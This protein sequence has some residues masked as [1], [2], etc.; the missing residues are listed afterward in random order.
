MMAMCRAT[1]RKVALFFISAMTGVLFAFMWKNYQDALPLR[2]RYAQFS[3]PFDYARTY[4]EWLKLREFSHIPLD[5]EMMSYSN[6]SQRNE[7][8]AEFLFNHVPIICIVLTERTKSAK[9]VSETWGKHCNKLILFGSYESTEPLVEKVP[10]DKWNA[11]PEAVIRVGK[12]YSDEFN[13]TIITDDLTYVILENL[14]YMVAGLNSTI[15]YYLGHTMHQSGWLYNQINGG[16]VLSKGALVKLIDDDVKRSGS[17]YSKSSLSE[18][19]VLGKILDDLGVYPTDTRD[20]LGRGR[21]NLYDPETLLIPGTLSMFSYYWRKSLYIS[22][23]GSNCCS[24]YA[25]AFHN[26]SPTQMYAM[27]YLI[28]HLRPFFGGGTLGGV[29]PPPPVVKNVTKTSKSAK[30]VTKPAVGTGKAVVKKITP[31]NGNSKKDK[32]W[33]KRMEEKEKKT[34]DS[35]KATTLANKVLVN[36][37]EKLNTTHNK[38][39]EKNITASNTSE[40]KVITNIDKK[41]NLSTYTNTTKSHKFAANG[42][43]NETVSSN[44]NSTMENSSMISIS[45]SNVTSTEKNLTIASSNDS[46]TKNVSNMIGNLYN[47]TTEKPLTFEEVEETERKVEEILE[48]IF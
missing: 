48:R 44:K 31:R 36:S 2:L 26:I 43:E 5:Q 33:K 8:E 47:V 15:P 19:K 16:I 17:K 23:D 25:I 12:G 42:K 46:V 39:I 11:I 18:E 30:K 22:Q 35:K 34:L 7:T 40:P 38:T 10:Q 13:W 1:W 3:Q 32:L 41:L 37:V 24:D 20:M 28:F 14:R 27:E 45:T 4:N 29:T 21:F 6:T 9:A